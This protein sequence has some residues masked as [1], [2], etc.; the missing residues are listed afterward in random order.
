MSISVVK[1]IVMSGGDNTEPV[2][3][4]LMLILWKKF[5]ARI[6]QTPDEFV[7][8]RVIA[9]RSRGLQLLV[10]QYAIHQTDDN[11]IQLG[12]IT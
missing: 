9:F 3:E 4:R 11:R 12:M 10:L 6:V 7:V 8:I 1:L 2:S 5:K